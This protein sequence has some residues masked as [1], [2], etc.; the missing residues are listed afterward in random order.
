MWPVRFRECPSYW[1]GSI[2]NVARYALREVFAKG[3]ESSDNEDVPIVG[4]RDWIRLR[5][6]MRKKPPVVHQSIS[7]AVRLR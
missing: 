5:E 6:E 7:L 4:Q 3:G 2:L 1:A